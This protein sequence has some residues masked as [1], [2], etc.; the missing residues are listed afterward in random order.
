[1]ENKHATGDSWEIR[2]TGAGKEGYSGNVPFRPLSRANPLG[3]VKEQTIVGLKTADLTGALRGAGGEG[4]TG[5]CFKQLL[6]A[7]SVLRR[8]LFQGKENWIV[9][10]TVSLFFSHLPAFGAPNGV[11][12]RA[13]EEIGALLNEK[14]S[15]TPAQSKMESQ[16]IHALKNNRGQAFATGVKRLQ[17]EVALRPD[18]RALVDINAKVTPSLLGLIERGGGQVMNSFQRFHAVRALVPLG[19]LETLA[20][21]DDVIFIRRAEQAHTHAGIVDSQGDVTHRVAA[22]RTDFGVTGSG[23]KVGVLSDSVDYLTNSQSSGDLG[24]V[25]VL[26]GQAGKGTGE[27]TA[28]LQIIHD[29]APGSQLFFATAF[30]SQASFAQNILDLRNAGCDIIVDDAGYTSESPFQD[31]IIAQAVNSV[32]ASGALYFSAAANAG[33]QDAGT[34]GTWEGDFVDGG[35]V[36]LPIAEAGRVHTFGAFTY[37]TAA[38]GR[39]SRGVDLFWADPLGASTND[40]DLFVLDST[41]S[42]VLRSSTTPQTG[43]QDPYE[44]ISTLNAGERIVIVKYSGETRFLHLDTAG[45]R[46]SIS[47]AGA[48]SG[49]SA[50]TN[51]LSVAAVNAATAYP[52]AFT[53]GAANPVESF[54]SDGPRQVFFNADGTAISPT[55]FSSTGGAIRQKPDFAAAD[56][57]STTVPGFSTFFGTS[58]A[59][60]H[61]AGIAALLL[62]YNHALTPAQV[63]SA[64][65]STALD[66]GPPGTDR[67][68]GAGIVM[69]YLPLQDMTLLVL[70]PATATEGDGVLTSRGQVR[71]AAPLASNLT[72]N[73]ASSDTAEA[74]VPSSLIILAGDTKAFFDITI[75]DD[76]ILD[77]TRMATL[78]AS[79]PGYANGST[80][81][82]V[83]DNETAILTVNAPASVVEGDS[84][85][86]GTVQVSAPPGSDVQINLLSSDA[87]EIQVPLSV[88]M[89]AG[90]TS[91]VFNLTVI[92]NGEIE[93]DQTATITAH[94]ANWTDGMATIIVHD[95]ADT[96]LVVKLPPNA[97][98]GDG[99]LPNAGSVS[100][101]GYL[102]TNLVVALTVDD[103]TEATVPATVT[104]LAGQKFASFDVTIIDD[105]EVDGVQIATVTA[106]AP[107]FSSGSAMIAVYDNESPPL[108][109]APFP[110]DLSSNIPARLTLRWKSIARVSEL[111]TNGGFETGDFTGWVKMASPNGDFIINDGTVDP[112]STDGPLPPYA[113]KESALAEH[114]GPGS[115]SIYQQLSIPA[116]AVGATLSWAHRLRNFYTAW[117]PFQEFRV[118]IQDTSGDVLAVAF[119][120]QPGD[121][122]MGDW[123]TNSFDLGNLIGQTIRV[124]YIVNPGGFHLDV[125]LDSVSVL[126]GFT[127]PF[128]NDVYLGTNPNPG[129]AELQGNT[130]N[131]SW[132]LPL[133]APLTTYYWKI[134]SRGPS[135]TTGPVWQFITRGANHFEWSPIPS[136]QFV[137]EPFNVAITAKDEFNTTVSNF[138]GM[139][140]LTGSQH[141][142]FRTNKILNDALPDNF[143]D[144]DSFTLGYSFTP[145]TNLMVTHVRH[146]SGTKVSIW[147]DAGVLLASQAVSSIPGTWVETP[148]SVPL[149]LSAGS[150]FRVAFYS[151]NGMFYWGDDQPSAFP[152]GT[153]NQA[154]EIS[155]DAFPTHRDSIRWWAVDLRYQVA[156]SVPVAFI[157]TN[158][159]SFSNGIWSG[160][161]TVA[162]PAI[163]MVVLADD[164]MGHQASGNS[165]SVLLHDDIG[166]TMTASPEPSALGENLTYLIAI[167]NIGPSRAMG[168]TLTDV[169]PIG[170]TLVSVTASQGACTNTGGII[171]CDLG[172]FAAD[173]NV[174]ITVVVTPGALGNITNR[175]DLSRSEADVFSGNNSALTITSVQN[176]SLAINDTSVLEGN[177]GITSA[178]FTVQLSPVTSNTVTVNFATTNG[179]ALA[180]ID[181]LETNGSLIFLP[182]ETS[183]TIGVAVIGDIQ[184]EMDE[185]CMVNLSSP[186]N[187]VL[188]RSRGTN[189]ILN[190]DS[191]PNVSISD[192][193]VLEGNA[194]AT[195][196][197]FSLSVFPPSSQ[198]ITVVYETADGSAIAPSDYRAVT[199][200]S[201]TFSPGQTNATIGVTVYG[202][203]LIEPDE[204]FSVHL[205]EANNANIGAGHAIGAIINDDGLPG[206]VDHFT[207]DTIPSLQYLGRPFTV[208]ITAQ[209][210]F[211]ATVTNFSATVALSGNP[212][213]VS[214]ASSG[215]FSNGVWMGNMTMLAIGANVQL[216]ADDRDGHAGSGNGFDVF[217]AGDVS[218][219]L[220]ASP[221]P[222][223]TNS[224][225]MYTLTVFNPGPWPATG[226]V[227]S[228]FLPT[229][230]LFVSVSSSQGSCAHAG[231]AVACNLGTLGPNSNA[232]MRIVALSPSVFGDIIDRATMTGNEADPNPTNNAS[233][234]ITTVLDFPPAISI[235]SPTN[236]SR[237]QYPTNITIV[238]AASDIE[239]A[240]TRVEF[241]GNGLKWGESTNSPFTLPWTNPA[242]GQ[243]VLTAKATDAG[244][245]TAVSDPTG[246]TVLPPLPGQGLGVYAEYFNNTNFSAAMTAEID[247]TIYFDASFANFP[248]AGF[249]ADTFSARWT[250]AVQPFYSEIY[251]F[252]TYADQGVR[253]YI[254]G[255]LL[256][257]KFND[258]SPKEN[259][260]VIFLQAGQLYSMRMEYYQSQ[261]GGTAWL[262][263]SSINQSKEIIP[264]SQLY[265]LPLVVT[266]P[267]SQT[268]LTGANVTVSGAAVGQFPLTYQWFFNGDALPAATAPDLLL[269]NAQMSAAGNYSLSASNAYGAVTSKVAIL[270]MI[271]RD[272]DGDGMPDDWEV[273]HGLNPSD[274]S[275]ASA[276]PDHDGMSNLD[277]YLSGTDPQDPLSVLKA[278]LLD[279]HN[280]GAF[281]G[282]TA[283]PNV[284]YTIQYRTNWAQG[285]WRKLNDV[286]AQP[287]TNRIEMFD[288]FPGTGG[289]RYYR[290]ATPQ[291]P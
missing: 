218:L 48:T 93:G 90:Q 142:G 56:G 109:S 223:S 214:P 216:M 200:G 180:G 178:V 91:A 245:K 26:P 139:V 104:I 137:N 289:R 84:V 87:T 102:P 123:A 263:W 201:V 267:A 269:T 80:S 197:L 12:Q 285:T 124:A 150:T 167:T 291:Q 82:A 257:D 76:A 69:A 231:N 19:Q 233:V 155:G 254:D 103:T 7:R 77:G 1:M 198:T 161:L 286:A 209:D 24:T 174:F 9:W 110:P 222:I 36:S 114:S 33:N 16:L 105:T 65:T 144:I 66:I 279:A 226:I 117:T 196:L 68:S 241:F 159:G 268:A 203:T 59:A 242:P 58:A 112:P 37:N 138:T 163:N 204:T 273:A 54:S 290:I 182:G 165:F 122:L 253:L 183:K 28:L 195:N 247:P 208:R 143:G 96:N 136:T 20:S 74:T 184:W 44:N 89:P 188:G 67:N 132:D 129:P 238:A 181:Y 120:T 261:P 288:P 234:A 221:G 250:G 147:T 128:T 170:V 118:E 47:T 146:Y 126:A 151:D 35:A 148:L 232:I 61:A 71:I 92:D 274:P 8:F 49:H 55:D 272:S 191:F 162:E 224:P 70:A 34:S 282:F 249:P 243:Y 287:G 187:A 164:G 63:R 153:I 21:S 217:G 255:Q 284:G 95:H 227:L 264:Q 85:I 111:I 60:A 280:G 248:P 78:T 175:V 130:T 171:T 265:P 236:G 13:L 127:I 158:A 270:R 134:V 39:I 190:D 57:V 99:V 100:I 79:A 107:G 73:L 189:I 156:V 42:N 30:N 135:T 101:S 3:E 121:P 220:S 166:V 31:A 17:M 199:N 281:M 72:V 97:T 116:E 131:L 81:I 86:H 154:Y 64:L 277:E 145:N 14:A 29:L 140:A 38:P 228:N 45:G 173:T 244:G 235:T 43:T 207:W 119:A 23:V 260:A 169:L 168:V 27:G 185:T 88:L 215:N 6:P 98:E 22:A 186:S 252:Y 4:W 239:G 240:V 176:V 275:D 179:T 115:H 246:I 52:N 278:Q 237:C 256:M 32:T 25:M 11:N 133:L 202:D 53:G 108:P 229:G 149:W 192:A 230:V 141:G 40:Y 259:S 210:I 50:A 193:A 160:N 62:S 283:M 157:P 2:L 211:N 205:L 83:Q 177:D 258:H 10:L 262:S 212:L 194:G 219:S 152:D 172:T 41:G 5:D 266:D 213:A 206:Q 125:H 113:G 225:F 18:G 271:L 15:W 46:L 51:A 106:S 251:T 94:V 276:D 75:V